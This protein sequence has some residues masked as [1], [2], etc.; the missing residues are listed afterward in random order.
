LRNNNKNKHQQK[1]HSKDTTTKTKLKK[2]KTIYELIGFKP[3][4]N[5]HV[6]PERI[7][8]ISENFSLLTKSVHKIK[9]R[10]ASE[11]IL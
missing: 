2:K 1:Q 11:S 8:N 9:K 7:C 4:S 6:G 10:F 5:L 3:I